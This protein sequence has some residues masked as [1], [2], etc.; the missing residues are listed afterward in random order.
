VRFEGDLPLSAEELKR[1]VKARPGKKVTYWNLQDDADRA[2]RRLV[3]AG[4]VEALVSA[5]LEG[6]VATFKVRSGAH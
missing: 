1:S 6:D 4:Y 3:D 5:N 2:Q